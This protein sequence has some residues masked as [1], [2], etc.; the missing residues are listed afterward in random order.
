MKDIVTVSAVNFS[1]VWGDSFGNRKRMV[2]YSEAL[3]RR[4]SDFIIFPETALT[5]YD[6]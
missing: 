1:A 4:G 5:G 2:E 6:V 3:A